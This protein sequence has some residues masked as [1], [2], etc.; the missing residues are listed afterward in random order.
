MLLY[1]YTIK[2]TSEKPTETGKA[3]KAETL[4]LSF[5][6]DTIYMTPPPKQRKKTKD[7]QMQFKKLQLAL[8]Q[9]V[10]NAAMFKIQRNTNI[11]THDIVSD[12]AKNNITPPPGVLLPFS[13][14]GQN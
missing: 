14:Y 12:V 13:P 1:S 5:F 8:A 4:K 10:Q 6:W 3:I 2:E 7:P 11:I 9:F